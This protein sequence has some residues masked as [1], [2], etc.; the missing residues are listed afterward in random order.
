MK[1]RV[2]ARAILQLRVEGSAMLAPLA[3]PEVEFE[4]SNRRQSRLKLN[5]KFNTSVTLWLPED[6][7]HL[8]TLTC[9]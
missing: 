4:R 8:L 7:P 1:E 5:I 2:K 3:C 6:M 9:A